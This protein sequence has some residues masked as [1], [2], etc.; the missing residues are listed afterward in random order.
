MLD[1]PILSRTDYFLLANKLCVEN[2]FFAYLNLVCVAF[3]TLS[4]ALDIVLARDGLEYFE[5]G[6]NVNHQV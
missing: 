4:T 6:D 1:K 2:G 3:S 5:T